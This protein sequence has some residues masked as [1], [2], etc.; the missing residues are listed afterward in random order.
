MFSSAK[1]AVL[2]LIGLVFLGL[3]LPSPASAVAWQCVTYA[4]HVS[5]I[6]IRGN[7]HTWWE[8]ADGVYARGS[9]PVVGS[10][11]VLPSHGRMRLGHVAMVSEIVDAREIRIDHANWSGR[12]VVESRAMV[13][14][15]SANNDWSRVKVWYGRIGALGLT[16]YPVAG[17]IYPD[18]PETAPA[19]PAIVMASAPRATAAP[20]AAALTSVTFTLR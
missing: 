18:A 4:R 7:A 15:V 8:Q 5:A 11:M 6:E 14:D 9:T 19:L 3:G 2:G 12:G 16:E 1:R 13:R 20:L 17:F 10:V